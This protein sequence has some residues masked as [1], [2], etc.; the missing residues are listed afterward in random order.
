MSAIDLQ[1][2]LVRPLHSQ[3]ES[4]LELEDLHLINFHSYICIIALF[5]LCTISLST[6]LAPKL[7]NQWWMHFLQYASKT[8][9]I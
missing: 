6:V 4:H 2:P 3:K 8:L 1:P 7:Y 5:P 9:E